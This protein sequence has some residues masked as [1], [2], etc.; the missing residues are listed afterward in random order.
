[1]LGDRAVVSVQNPLPVGDWSEPQP[2]VTVLRP[3]ADFYA[4]GHPQPAD[5]LLVIEVADTTVRFD[6][7]VKA[8]LYAEQ[9]VDEVWIVDVGAEVVEVYRQP[10]LEGYRAVGR[11]GRGEFIAP[12]AFPD[13]S[14]GVDEILG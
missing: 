11:H 12:L 7:M 10:S 1:M 8:P 6:R 13:V 5:V 14:V 9:G 2:D 3:R 4:G